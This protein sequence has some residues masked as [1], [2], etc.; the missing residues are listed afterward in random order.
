MRTLRS[1]GPPA[2]LAACLAFAAVLVV[3]YGLA[4]HDFQPDEFDTVAGGRVFV[5]H[6]LD[7]LFS[8]SPEGRGPERLPALLFAL[9]TALFADTATVFKAAHVLFALLYVSA[10]VPIYALARGLG[11]GR[12]EAVLPAAAAAITPWMLFGGT[13]LNTTLAYPTAMALAWATWRAAIRPGLM[14]DVWV[15]L[16]G[17]LGAMAREG[18]AAFLAAAA[19]VLV[20]A[21]WR[22]RPAGEGL[23]ASARAYPGRLLR[24][25]PLL[26]GAAAALVLLVLLYG[27]NRLL[28]SA[29][30]PQA[31]RQPVTLSGVLGTISSAAAELT[32]GTGYLPMMI[33]LPWLARELVRPRSR[34]TGTLALLCVAMFFA[35]VG[36]IVYYS[37]TTS[38]LADNERYVSV[39][40]G[41]PPL[42]A[43]VSLFRRQ[44]NPLAVAVA[45]VLLSRAIVTGGLYPFAGPFDYFVAPA[46]L[47]F[48]VV[49]QGQVSTRLPFSDAHVAATILLALT[50]AAVV[51][52]V[53]CAGPRRVGAA[54]LAACAAVALG[55]PIA[56]GAA[57]G[58]YIGNHFESFDTFPSI[59]FAQQSFADGAG[60][61]RPVAFW[62]Y[63]PGGDPR[64]AYAA[65]QAAFFNRWV[66]ATLHLDGMPTAAGIGTAIKASVDPASGRL[67][68]SSR[69]PS[70]LL[71]PERFTRIGFAGAIVA[72]PTAVFGPLPYMLL[73]IGPTPTVAYAVSG[74]EEAGTI[75]A[76]ADVARIDLYP[77]T[78]ASCWQTSLTAP[79]TL[80]RSLPYSLSGPGVAQRGLLA[81]STVVPIRLK[82]PPRGPIS[83]TLRGA[84]TLGWFAPVACPS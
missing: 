69:L 5:N 54:G 77:T 46:R 24:A 2:V 57:S 19:V 40:A 55:A 10:A 32:M 51:I 7:T 37:A 68:T 3:R 72:P 1:W 8:V 76:P 16:F 42:A 71:A 74:T 17:V 30:Q 53:L 31:S 81:A 6:F 52:A 64:I 35:F 75:L 62:D 15:L 50:A 27:K 25:H 61:D 47:F 63:A 45:G 12:A 67:S 49:I 83:L 14:G 36:M 44:L 41:L 20:V 73:R 70:Y 28:G 13:L 29:Y 33:A 65:L 59:S 84:G 21:L 23:R 48:T 60:H 66:N 38:G 18:H 43:A 80:P 56:L 4:A 9:P 11:L 58:I 79:P 22:E 78:P 82:S 26:C 34:E 39:L